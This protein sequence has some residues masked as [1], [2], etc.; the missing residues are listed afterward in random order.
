MRFDLWV[1]IIKV[2]SPKTSKLGYYKRV[3]SKRYLISEIL[4]FIKVYPYHF[5]KFLKFIRVDI[6]LLIDW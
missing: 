1:M 6:K 4:T 3:C 5:F 2:F